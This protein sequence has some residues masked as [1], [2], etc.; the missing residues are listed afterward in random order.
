MSKDNLGGIFAILKEIADELGWNYSHGNMTEKSFKAVNV[1]PLQHVT[2]NN[3][4]VQ[5]QIA[6]YSVNIII[7]DL[8]NFLKTENEGLNPVVLYSEI[9]YTENTNYAHVLQE[10]YV[11]FNLKVREKRLQYAEDIN[12]VYPLTFN[13][14]IDAE[15][16]V[17]AGYTI[18]LTIEGRA[19]AVID[20]YNEV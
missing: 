4:T 6:T 5:E 9:G 7:A 15:A 19:P 1:Y 20:C 11:L 10:L 16:D 13:P 14:F 18:T 2:I 12:I 3:I 8:V 17:L